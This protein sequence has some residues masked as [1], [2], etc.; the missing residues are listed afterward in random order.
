MQVNR[1]LSAETNFARRLL[2]GD[3]GIFVPIILLLGDLKKSNTRTK[4][5]G[6]NIKKFQ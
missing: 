3:A 5:A 4:R 6:I 2:I 1:C